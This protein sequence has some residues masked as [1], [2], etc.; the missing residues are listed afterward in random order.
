MSR[1]GQKYSKNEPFFVLGFVFTVF[2]FRSMKKHVWSLFAGI[3]ISLW[4]NTQSYKP[5][6]D[7]FNEWHFTTCFSGCNTVVYYTDGDTLVGGF[8]YKILDG[9]HYTSRTVL[10]R[11]DVPNREVY[12]SQI[13][14]DKI[15]SFLLYDFKKQEGDSMELF[16]PISPFIENTGYFKL[17]SIRLKPLEDGNA[18]RHFYWSPMPGNTTYNSHP[19]WV[20]GVGSISLVNASSGQPDFNG[21]GQLN[22][23]FKN[24]TA[25]YVDLDSIDS[26]EPVYVLGMTELGKL[27]SEWTLY[28]NPVSNELKLSAQFPGQTY[29]I[30][31]LQGVEVCKGTID[32]DGAVR[33]ESLSNGQY[34][35]KVSGQ[36]PRKFNKRE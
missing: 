15:K 23:F 30:L 24:S 31:N 20:E 14:P 8:M 34:F 6:L 19:V 29:Q 28:P 1:V 9:Y 11:E 3:M 5:L 18:Y 36:N 26:C 25:F 33:V 16:N 10:L 2:Y 17:D 22:C 13:L 27:D 4:G 12:L 7:D 21:N 35:L 32:N